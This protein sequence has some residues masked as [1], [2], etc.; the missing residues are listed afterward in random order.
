MK[1]SLT[2]LIKQGKKRFVWAW[3]FALCLPISALLLSVF[4]VKVLWLGAIFALNV[5]IALLACVRMM[6]RYGELVCGHDAIFYLLSKL[7][8]Q[9]FGAWLATPIKARSSMYHDH[10]DN[11]LRL[12]QDIDALDQFALKIISPLLIA[13]VA[14]V[15]ATACI[16]IWLGATWALILPS[17][18]LWIGVRAQLR[19]VD[20]S[21]QWYY[22]HSTQVRTLTVYAPLTAVFGTWGQLEHVRHMVSSGEKDTQ[23]IANKINNLQ[24]KSRI[25]IGIVSVLIVLVVCMQG[26]SWQ[27]VAMVFVAVA[28]PEFI[29][30]LVQDVGAWGKVLGAKARLNALTHHQ[31]APKPI[32]PNAS[33][34][35][36]QKVAP[37][38]GKSV[39]AATD[40]HAPIGI[41]HL[42]GRSG[43]GKSTLLGAIADECAY[44][45][46]ILVQV[47][48]A[49][50]NLHEYSS[51][52]VAMLGQRADI[53]D[54][55]L[56]DNLCL[57]RDIDDES[58]WQMLTKLDLHTWVR[59]LDLGLDTPLGLLGE[60]LSGGQARR[61]A[62]ARILLTPA[63]II[64]LDEPFVGLDD[65]TKKQVAQAIEV[66]ATSCI[67]IITSHDMPN[68]AMQTVQFG[69]AYH[70]G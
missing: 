34:L 15:V 63:P 67:V 66:L 65:A 2:N 48:N 31:D 59:T 5:A 20:L 53:F 8:G 4:S 12:T 17:I 69:S 13:L 68:L 25:G 70:D 46:E 22:A 45:G 40:L 35:R 42:A 49:W 11:R 37:S 43:V 60:N 3:F 33:A 28:L 30:P 62:L 18:M 1:I 6:A 64:L 58:L 21:S 41:T 29:L 61:V 54:L 26:A 56:R 52:S 27:G 55:S 14:V 7:R 47:D 50:H 44:T 57:G 36:L 38:I 19:A 32:L 16:L 39:C 10:D 9:F 51:A 24:I 23:V